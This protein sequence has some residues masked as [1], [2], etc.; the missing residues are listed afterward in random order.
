MAG[1]TVFALWTEILD[2]PGFVVIHHEDNAPHQRHYFTVAPWH[3]IGICPHC[4]K[5]S[6]TVKQ[7]RHREGILDLPIGSRSVE[8]SVR[9]RQFEC[10]H[11][12]RCFTPP[13]DFLADGAHATERL[14]QRAADLIQHSDVTN[15]A[16]FFAIPEKNLERWYYDFLEQQQ[17]AATAVP[18]RPIRRIGIDELSLK[19]GTGSSSP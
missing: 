7:C 17:Q 3:D 18:S 14:L 19:K 13:I 4:G 16:R 15:A 12:G 1:T 2:L 8:L 6:E 11:C 9:V 10:E 5:P